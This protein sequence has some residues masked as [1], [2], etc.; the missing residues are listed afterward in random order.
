MKQL[1]AV[2][3]LLLAGFALFCLLSGFGALVIVIIKISSAWELIGG[4]LVGSAIVLIHLLTK[5][6]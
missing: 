1:L 4:T 2:F 6:D 5:K 3:I